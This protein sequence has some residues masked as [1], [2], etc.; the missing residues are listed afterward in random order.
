[1]ASTHKQMFE[2]VGA[3]VNVADTDGYIDPTLDS[4]CQREVRRL[5]CVRRL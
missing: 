2:G 3:P 4:C 1:M 5:Q